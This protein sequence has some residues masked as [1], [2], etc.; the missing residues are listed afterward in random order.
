M[1]NSKAGL[2][3]TGKINFSLFFS[4]KGA[5]HNEP[6]S[7]ASLLS[8][9]CSECSHAAMFAIKSKPLSPSHLQQ[10]TTYGALPQLKTHTLAHHTRTHAHTNHPSHV[11]SQQHQHHVHACRAGCGPRQAPEQAQSQEGSRG[12][13][14]PT[15]GKTMFFYFVVLTALSVPA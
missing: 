11:Q 4:W 8:D 5:C 7:C 12:I 3:V 15:R 1:T 13:L 6:S 2:S 14:I 9:P 10:T